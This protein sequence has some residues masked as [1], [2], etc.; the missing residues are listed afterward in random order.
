MVTDILG[1]ARS[2][3]GLGWNQDYLPTLTQLGVRAAAKTGTSNAQIGSRILPKDIWTVGYTPSLSMAVWLGNPDTT[4]L[5]NGNSLIPAMFFD[6]TMAAATKIYVEAGKAKYSDWFKAPSGIQ[7]IRGEIYPS[8]YSKSSGVTN[9]KMTFDRVSKNRATDCTPAGARVEVGVSKTTDPITK[10]DVYYAS[11]GYDASKEDTIHKCNMD[12]AVT[13]SVSSSAITVN[14]TTK[15]PVQSVTLTQGGTVLTH[16]G[17]APWV[18]DGSD[19][20]RLSDGPFTVTV[21]D[22]LYYSKTASGNYSE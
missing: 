2:R 9:T 12:P 8:Y 15:N 1:D 4:P 17:G 5:G 10:K 19:L 21:T 20:A 11:D 13:V 18:I 14:Y 22:E 16:T 6:R 3:A 7:T